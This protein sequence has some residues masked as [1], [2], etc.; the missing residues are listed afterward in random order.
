[1]ATGDVKVTEGSGKNVA[2]YEVSES[3]ETKSIQRIGLNKSDGT[4]I[5]TTLN[6]VVV[7]VPSSVAVYFDPSAPA[8]STTLAGSM[9]VYFDKSNPSVNVG[10]PTITGITN[11]IAAHILST[12]GTL[13]VKLDPDS[14]VKN[15]NS[16][17][18]VYFSPANPTVSIGGQSA[19]LNVALDP[20]HTLGNIGS[21]GSITNTVAVYFDRASPAIAATFSGSIATYFDQ[22]EPTVKAKYGSGTFAV[23]FSPANPTV[24]FDKTNV[25]ATFTGTANVQLDPG[26]ELG[27]IKGINSTVAVY[28]SPANPAVAA[29]FSGT[30]A[31]YFD[32]SEPTIKAKYGSGTFAVSFDP[33]HEIGSIKQ[34][35]SSVAV[36]FDRGGPTVIA[37]PTGTQAVYFDQSNPN[38]K[39]NYGSGTFL[40]AFDRA[41]PSVNVGTPTVAA[42]TATVGVYFD[43]A[44]P[45]VTANA[46]TGTMTVAFDSSRGF[47]QGINTSVGVYFDRANPSVT[48]AN[49]SALAQTSSI[50]NASGSCSS[51]ALGGNTII[52][53]S[54]NYSFK[55]FALQLTTTAQT[56]IYA[57]FTNGASST[58]TEYW[59]YALQAPTQG[60]AGANLAINPPGYLFA[61]GT[62]T[63]LALLLDSGSLVHYSVSYIKE[64]A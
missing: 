8:V 15:I 17:V 7:S 53:P 52:S 62:S 51:A 57:R 48:I 41:N 32:Q 44:N 40:V 38:V 42:I 63:T 6:P 56:G 11:S 4:E 23:A 43:R 2:T 60:I 45:S 1:M 12:G 39:V 10:T 13:I 49:F 31:V 59:R 24:F 55:I 30:T 36:Y 33:G 61:T 50:F 18:A 28:F 22:S 21:V 14:G 16:T 54:A 58:P 35:N 37:S 9:A 25:D 3:A 29:T 34:I 47:L 19:T 5:G 20:G 64:T 26:H 46:G 27:S